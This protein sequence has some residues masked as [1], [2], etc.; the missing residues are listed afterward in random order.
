MLHF[1][2][3]NLSKCRHII[4]V[5]IHAIR[6]SAFLIICCP[7]CSFFCNESLKDWIRLL[8]FKL[9]EHKVFSLYRSCFSKTNVTATG[10]FLSQYKLRVKKASTAR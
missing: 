3:L 9:D 6:T 10:Y 4:I 1:Q 7:T 8:L 5:G 2:T